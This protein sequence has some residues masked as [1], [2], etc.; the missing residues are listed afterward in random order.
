M[1]INVKRI[2]GGMKLGVKKNAP[3]LLLAGAFVTGTACVVTSVRATI[4]ADTI[5]TKIAKS[6]EDMVTAVNEG[7]SELEVKNAMKSVYTEV[8]VDYI[9]QS[10]IP[11][12]LFVAT[13][14]LVF[15]SY[16]IQKS[17]QIALSSALASATLAYSTLL[18]KVKNGAEAGLTAQQVLD[19]VEVK[20]TINEETG[21][22]T[23]ELVQGAPVS[24]IYSFRFDKMAD[25]W[26]KDSYMNICTL[27]AEQ[28]WANNKLTLEGYLFL[29]DVLDRLGL[30]RTKEGQIV[31]WKSS[32]EGDG[33]VDFGIVDCNTFEGSSW[34]DNAYNLNF[35]CDG[36]I[37]TA[38]PR[39][40]E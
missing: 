2:I 34:D 22:V 8:V 37:L 15:A 3:E 1:S 26:E 36:D 39:T 14:G 30:G 33:Y 31:G 25:G 19:G 11:T 24:N 32:G 29:N 9:K 18:S 13:T 6:K 16:K 28:Q 12:T 40:N 17:R 7:Y 5:R 38:F 4:K 23:E 20:K 21:E 10:A 35:N 27:N